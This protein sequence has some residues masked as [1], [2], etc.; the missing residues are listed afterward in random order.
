MPKALSLFSNPKSFSNFFGN[1]YTKF[2]ILCIKFHFTCG[3]SDL[4]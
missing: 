3:E 1:W 4:Y 2:V